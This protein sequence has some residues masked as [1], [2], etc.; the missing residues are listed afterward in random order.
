MISLLAFMFMVGFPEKA[1]FLSED[2][3]QYIIARLAHD[4]GA[5]KAN[6]ITVKK[7]IYALKNWMIWCQ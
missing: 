6:K 5:S 3:K 1:K 7:V 4:A 2:D